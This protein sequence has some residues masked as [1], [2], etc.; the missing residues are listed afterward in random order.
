MFFFSIDFTAFNRAILLQ[1]WHLDGPKVW[2]EGQVGR[3]SSTQGSQLSS[4]NYLLRKP[5]YS[6]R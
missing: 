1:V 6:N 2:E 3:G 4:K 5:S